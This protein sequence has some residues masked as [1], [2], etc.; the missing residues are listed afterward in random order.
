MHR[1][2]SVAVPTRHRKNAL[3]NFVRSFLKTTKGSLNRPQLNILHDSPK[4]FENHNSVKTADAFA[5]LDNVRSIILP[6][7][8]GLAELWNWCVI[9][10]PTDWVLIC[11]DDIVFKK[12]WLQYL[13]R[14]IK[15]GF[16]QINIGHY[17]AFCLH[18]S[19]IL[20]LGWFDNRFLGGGFEDV[21]HQLR[22]SEAGLK[23]YVDISNDFKKCVNGIDYGPYV[24]HKKS[25]DNFGW[26]GMNNAEWFIEK[27]GRSTPWNLNIPSY[28]KYEEI[29]WYPSHTLKYTEKFDIQPEFHRFKPNNNPIFI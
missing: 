2:I 25:S 10:A 9:M 21:S 4:C 11:N 18:K 5:D 27:W 17:G 23:D 16:L 22:I 13:E 19:L 26:N 7:K 20:K 3:F 1:D 15:E 8:S 29:D 14:K 6:D 28:R 24:D 12:G